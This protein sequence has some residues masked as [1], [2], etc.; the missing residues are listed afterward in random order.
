[1]KH[2][3]VHDHPEA[4]HE[5]QKRHIGRPCD[6]GH[7]RVPP[8]QRAHAEHDDPRERGP[9]GREAEQR[10]HG[11]P[12]QRQGQDHEHEYRN[13]HGIDGRLR[14]GPHGQISRENPT[15]QQELDD[16]RRQPRGRH[17]RGE[18]KERQTRG[19]ERQQVG[20]VRHRQEQR[21]GVGQMRGG[22]G[23]RSGR[24]REHARCGEHNGRQQ[25]D[26]R[27]EAQY[28]RRHGADDE[29]LHQ[30]PRSVP[31][32]CPC[33]GST[34]RPEQTLVIAQLRQHQHGR[35]EQDHRKQLLDFVGGIPQRNDAGGDQQPGRGQGRRRLPASLAA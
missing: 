33:H 2:Q 3:A 14:V 23:V 8:G 18:V 24:N 28:G 27:V 31:V 7:G 19:T 22:V 6:A 25:H 26:S 5:H 20:Q 12:D 15:Q 32:G 30:Q 21:R 4:Q 35:E 9:C 17:H 29:H 34:C 11:E 1:M 16:H 13:P 10:R